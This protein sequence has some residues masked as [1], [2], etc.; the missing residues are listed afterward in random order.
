MDPISRTSGRRQ[1]QIWLNERSSPKSGP[2]ECSV[3]LAWMPDGRSVPPRPRGHAGR[4]ACHPLPPQILPGRPCLPGRRLRPPV[5]HGEACLAAA[6]CPGSS[7][8]CDHR[9][10]SQSAARL[11]GHCLLCSARVLRCFICIYRDAHPELILV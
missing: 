6:S 10:S 3:D 5:L 9:R 2:G 8:P 7:E 4:P 1:N 11:M